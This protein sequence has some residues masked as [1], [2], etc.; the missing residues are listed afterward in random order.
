[1]AATLRI[2]LALACIAVCVGLAHRPVGVVHARQSAFGWRRVAMC[3]GAPP[4]GADPDSEP[5]A[6]DAGDEGD[7]ADAGGDA[8]VVQQLKDEI[9]RREMDGDASGLD[10]FNS[11]LYDHLKRRPE[12]VDRVL[13]D[14]LSERIDVEENVFSK[15][16]QQFNST[17]K[18]EPTAGQTPGEVIELV[19]RALQDVDYPHEGHGVE[20]LQTFSSDACIAS[21]KKINEEM[22]YRCDAATRAGVRASCLAPRRPLRAPPTRP[23]PP[24]CAPRA[25]SYVK[26]SKYRI[27]L[28]WVNVMYSKKLDTSYEGKRAYQELRLKSGAS[29]Q[30][31]VINF[32][33]GLYDDIW[34]ID[35]LRVRGTVSNDSSASGRPKMDEEDEE[36]F[37]EPGAEP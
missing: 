22:L 13:Y 18:L 6:S 1:M 30:W 8:E 12:F 20:V 36:P 26:D 34:L 25:R 28:D 33:L 7:A 23:L 35:H 21:K 14:K 37:D 15:W 10:E 5:G 16:R 29:G 2:T 19:L 11:D 24:L 32:M 31:I 3:S 4:D 17:T 9:R 27:L